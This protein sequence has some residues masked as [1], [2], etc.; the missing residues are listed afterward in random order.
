MSIVALHTSLFTLTSCEDFLTIT[1][2]SAIVEEEFWQDKNDLNNAAVAC[3]KRVAS[4]DILTKIIYWGEMRSDN[5]DRSTEL[6]AS[7]PESNIMNANLLPTYGVFQWTPIYNVI[8]DCNKV[9]AHGPEVV[10]I[11]ESFNDGDWQPIRAEMITLRALCH[12]YLV[13]TF[14]EI[15][16]VTFD[17]NNNSQELRITQTPQLVVLDSIINDLESVKDVSMNDFG[18]D[19][20]NKGRITK[21]TVYSLLADVYLWRASYKA[22]NCEPFKNRTITPSIN[23]LYTDN[24]IVLDG[25]KTPYGTSA[26][27]DY[28]KCVECCDKVIE[29]CK[30][31]KIKYINEKG[32]NVGGAKIELEL[33]DLLVQNNIGT[34]STTSVVSAFLQNSNGA[35]NTIFGAG[36]S[37][38]SIFEI[39]FDGITYGNTMPTKLFWTLSKVGLFSAAAPLFE[40]VSDGPNADI[41]TAVFTKTDYRRAETL[42]WDRENKQFTLNIGKYTTYRVTQSNGTNK[43]LTDNT[44][45]NYTITSSTLTSASLEENWIMYRLSEI[46]LMKAE[47]MSQLYD[48]ETNLMTAFNYVREVFK[49]SNPYAY[50]PLNKTNAKT[51]T[52][53]FTNFNTKKGVEMLV[54]AER[55]REFIGEGKRWFDLVRF[56]QRRGNTEEMLNLLCRKYTGNQKAIRAKLADM[57]SLFSPVFDSEL[58]SNTWL[59][60]NGAWEV[61]KS[62]GRTDNL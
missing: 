31:E 60:Q 43:Y 61:N 21:K 44:A 23:T 52:L 50:S 33:E 11:D 39:Q 47:A 53:N 45:N 29:I 6:R 18:N 36:N 28:K 3:Y 9:L 20:L 51:D 22:G 32:L 16:Y 5:F 37:D 15:P 10:K 40:T 57:Q 4:E 17:Y 58:K 8:N 55:Q 7:S 35:Y 26:T 54:M 2:T 30:A 56:A 41:P 13:R 24:N 19:V 12:F 62:S 59:Y 48:D 34:N 46:Y 25:D 1:P 49:R 38:E 14:G 27:E 42:R